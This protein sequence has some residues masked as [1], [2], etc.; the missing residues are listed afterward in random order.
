MTPNGVRKVSHMSDCVNIKRV[1]GAIFSS[2]YCFSPTPPFSTTNLP[3]VAVMKY[4]CLQ[5]GYFCLFHQ[6]QRNGLVIICSSCADRQDLLLT[7][8]I[9]QEARDRTRAP[10]IPLN[11]SINII[12]RC[13]PGPNQ[14]QHPT[15]MGC[16]CVVLSASL[17]WGVRKDK[18]VWT[19]GRSE[20]TN[21]YKSTLWMAIIGS[22]TL[23]MVSKLG[24]LI[25][26]NNYATGVPHSQRSEIQNV[27]IIIHSLYPAPPVAGYAAVKRPCLSSTCC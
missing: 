20:S 21:R 27:H 8:S 19:Q 5:G 9:C 11:C 6:I 1:S 12:N 16:Q 23:F 15:N 10:K 22:P 14:S 25:S 2:V 3:L 4:H 13:A 26:H 7:S 24:E 17:G 18:D